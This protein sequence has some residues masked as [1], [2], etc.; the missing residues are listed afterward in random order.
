MGMQSLIMSRYAWDLIQNRTRERDINDKTSG[1]EH[2]QCIYQTKEWFVSIILLS[3]GWDTSLIMWEPGT[4]Q[5]SPG[6]LTQHP[7]PWPA[8]QPLP[9]HSKQQFSWCC[10]GGVPP[11]AAL[12][13]SGRGKWGVQWHEGSDL[14]V[15]VREWP[16]YPQPWRLQRSCKCQVQLK[17]IAFRE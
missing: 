11:P 10:S 7:T 15:P 13:D 4:H 8:W 17:G 6:V 3:L 12:Q 1:F 5:S 2:I 16:H 14:P 9:L